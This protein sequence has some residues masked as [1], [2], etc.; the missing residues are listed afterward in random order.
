MTDLERQ[1]RE[2]QR[3]ASVALNEERRAPRVNDAAFTYGLS[4]SSLYKLMSEG[5]L[6]SV[7]V[8]GRRL[9]PRE[10]MEALLQEGE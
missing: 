6:A 2:N 3:R 9:I 10:S 5:K 8:A 1:R 4:R 7:K